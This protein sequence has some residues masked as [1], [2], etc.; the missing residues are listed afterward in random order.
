[1]IEVKNLVK[2]FKIFHNK[3]STFFEML[4]NILNKKNN[5]EILTVLNNISFDLY[6][7]EVLGVMGRNGSGKTTLLKLIAKILIPQQGYIK[8]QGSIIPLLGLGIG[9]QPE[10]T[11]RDNIIQY[12]MILGFTKN[13]MIDKVDEIFEFAE[14]T[15]FIDTKIK[16]YSSGMLARIAFATAMQ[17]DPDI[18][19]VDEVLAVGDEK[20]RQKSSE[21]FLSFKDNKKSIIYVSHNIQS[22]IDLCDRAIL[23]ENG[24]IIS[25]GDPKQVAKKYFE[26]LNN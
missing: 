16:N 5:F 23:L 20:F 13:Q 21:Q 19:L 7:G 11:A 9:F 15:K 2:Q 24:K 10:F 8:T 1:M 26:L 3:K 6:P 18:L 4:L 17:V 25:E 12:G 22:I 14:L